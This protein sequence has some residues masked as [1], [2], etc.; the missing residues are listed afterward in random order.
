MSGR[1]LLDTNIVIALLGEDIAV[2]QS[3]GDAREVFLSSIVLGELHY[4]ARNSARV[5]ENLAVIENMRAANVVLPCDATT[6]EHYGQIKAELRLAGTPIP[7]NDIW[8]AALARQHELT[9]VSRD[10]H[11]ANVSGIS[12]EAW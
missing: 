3:L 6:S 2:T 1:F 9:L 11:F 7:E 12:V 5:V 8:I 4:G 10:A